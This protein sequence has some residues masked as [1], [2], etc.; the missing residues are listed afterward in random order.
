M[1]K[2]PLILLSLLIVV[3]FSVPISMILGREKILAEGEL[4]LFKTRP[5]DPVDF[6]QGRYV[7]LGIKEDYISKIKTAATALKHKQPIYALIDKD[8][9]GFAYFSDWSLS[10]PE[11][12]PYLKTRYTGYRHEWDAA[13]SNRVYRGIRIDIPFDRYYMDETK[14]PKAEVL[15]REATVSSNCWV[16]VRVIG[17]EAVIEDVFA[18]GQSINDAVE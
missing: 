8:E 17:G 4:F 10:E 1:K 12:S 7:R 5:V 15:A 14:A 13:T 6:F 16:A 18:N 9:D 3:Q 2:L 11:D